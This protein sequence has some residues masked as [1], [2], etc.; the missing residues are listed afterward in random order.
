[1]NMT[2]PSTPDQPGNTL[3][4]LR[5]IEKLKHQPVAGVPL[6][7]K[8]ALLRTW[9]SQRLARTYVRRPAGRPA[10]PARCEFFLEDIYAARDFSQRDHDIEQMYDFMQ[11]VF[12]AS[13]IRPLKLTVE[14]TDFIERGYKAFRHRS[15]AQPTRAPTAG[16]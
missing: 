14:L 4:I 6:D 12:P 13:L 2:S 10:L 3:G 1:M 15:A 16:G 5:D 11:R 7:P 8:L 9:Q